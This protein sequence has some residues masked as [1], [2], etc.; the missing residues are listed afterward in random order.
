MTERYKNLAGFEFSGVY[1]RNREII[2][3]AAQK[4]PF[5]DFLEQRDTAVFFYYPPD[6]PDK[7]WAFR[8]LGEAT[9]IHMCPVFKPNERWVAVT[10]DGEVYIVGQ[11][12][13]DWEKAISQKPNLYF[14]NVKAI[15]KGHAIAVGGRRKVFLRNAANNWIQLDNG[16]F[17]Q[18]DK[19]NL[20][21]AGFHDIDG[22][23]ENDMYACG[24][25]SDLW[26]F[27]GNIWTQIDLP[28]NAVL[29]N[30]CC[31]DDGFAYITTNTRNIL[32]GR[33][34]AWEIIDQQET[35]EVLESIVWYNGKVLVSTVSEIYTVDG[36]EFKVADLGTPPMTCKAH[37][38]VGDGIL[39]VA[40]RDEA[41]M[42]DGQSWSVIL[43]P[44]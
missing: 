17:S 40:G 10:D 20:E 15:C 38:A 13:D 6:P 9:G 11:G 19:T 26:H 43:E 30:I 21:Y 1:V 24:G 36:S 3:F 32:K 16:L 5:D 18:G 27:D 7:K 34:A 42:Y 44:A 35:T 2:G 12:D 25:K 28:T 23:S 37:L 22:F 14:S 41:T 8:Y 29:E 33:K 39:V 4:G 31:A